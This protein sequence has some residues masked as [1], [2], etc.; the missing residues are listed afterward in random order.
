MCLTEWETEI[1]YNN[2]ASLIIYKIG[3]ILNS[4]Y[5]NNKLISIAE[6]EK[7]FFEQ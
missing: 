1:N 6:T 2:N 7:L 5:I 3:F 4:L